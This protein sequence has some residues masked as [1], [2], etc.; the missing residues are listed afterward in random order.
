MSRQENEAASISNA[1]IA[2]IHGEPLSGLDQQLWDIF[3]ATASAHP[4]REAIVSLWQPADANQSS[5]DAYPTARSECLRWSYRILRDKAEHLADTLEKLGVGPGMHVAAVLWNCVEWSLLFWACAKIGAAFVPID[6]RVTD[7]FHFM[8]ESTTPRVLVVQDADIAVR[9]A[10]ENMGF[11]NPVL[12]IHCGSDTVEGWIGLHELLAP[13]FSFQG[14]RCLGDTD[15]D[16]GPPRANGIHGSDGNTPALIVFTSGTTGKPKGCPHTNRNLV[17]QTNNYDP[18]VD[19]SFVDRW[20]VHTPVCH[21]FAINNALRAWR[22]GGTVVFAAKSFHIDAT[23]RAL[24]QEKCTVMSA[25][26]TLVKA[27]LSHSSFPS[28]EDL[29]LSVVSISG[30]IIGP[31]HMRLCR[32]GLGARDAIQAYGMSEGAPIISWSR[33]DGMLVD[34]YHPGVGKVLPGA[35]VRVCRQDSR[36]V[37]PRMKIG[38]LHVAGPSVIHNYFGEAED[39]DDK[40][41]NDELGRWLKTGDQAMIDMEGVVYIF[42]RYNDLIIR[43]GENINPLK[44]ESTLTEIPGLLQAFIVGVPDDI[45]GQVPIAVVKLS[46]EVSKTVSKTRVMEKA[47]LLG[48]QHTLDAVYTLEDLGLESVPVTSIG[49]P[50]RAMLADMVRKQRLASRGEISKTGKRDEVAMLEEHLGGVWNQLVGVRPSK[51]DDVFCLA[52]SITLLRYCDAVL[53]V[54]GRRLYLQDLSTCNT[55]EKQAQLLATRDAL[56]GAGAAMDNK[57]GIVKIYPTDDDRNL[58]CR[59]EQGRNFSEHSI[60]GGNEMDGILSAAREQVERFGLDGSV[61]EDIIPIRGS[62]YR[63]VVGQR[64]QSY[65]I[66]VVF[67]VRDV[68]VSQIYDG[69]FQCLASRPLLRTVLLGTQGSLYHTVIRHSQHLFQKLVREVAAETEKEAKEV[70]EESADTSSPMFMF[71]AVIIKVKEK[72]RYLLCLTYSHS[73]ADTLTL[74]SWHRDIDRLIHSSD[75]AIPIQ[76]PYRLFADLFS[77]YH[78]SLPAQRAISFHVRRLRGI[79]RYRGAL[80]PKQRSP[81]MMIAGDEDSFYFA[82]RQAA[83]D[84]IWKGEWQ[85][86]ADEFRFPRRGRIVRLPSMA[87]MRALYNLE[88]VLFTK[89]ALVLFNVIQTRSPVALLNSWESARSWPFVPGWIADS[90]QPAMSIDGPTAQWILNMFQ[91]DSQETLADFIRRMVSEQEQICRHEHVPWEQVVQELREEGD[92]AMDASFRQSFVWDVSMG[93]AASRGFRSDFDTLEP[94]ARYDW[95]DCGL[96]WSAFMADEENLFFIAS[97]D[98]AQLNSEEVDGYCDDLAEVMRS[99]ANENNW[100]LKV[101]EVFSVH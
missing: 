71:G 18:N 64:P 98:T 53:R 86:R 91:V 96:F 81:G 1:A 48:A 66:R 55:I 27:L 93:V 4:D 5:E 78:A 21:V 57:K 45:A 3:V 62:L 8:L 85:I 42:G 20:L 68:N 14:H 47:R 87:R 97:W 100:S 56:P 95:P 9:L 35:A 12:R 7:D 32:E 74:L 39:E 25:T 63:T 34:G 50:K 36:E 28:P 15:D 33:Q 2:E 13:N 77:E 79:S 38:E 82:E 76:T 75:T 84:R 83:R 37:L 23:L 67:R 61:V 29:N 70:Y 51:T 41:Y 72:G 94:V 16:H 11:P 19:T 99:L 49:K 10:K 59:R 31:E 92:V 44:I 30:T 40:F 89:C 58:L 22:H 6:P 46:P 90:L 101:G 54:Y 80:W 88:P 17:S 69:L 65:R 73:I 52:D 43:G 26:P 60:F 24:A